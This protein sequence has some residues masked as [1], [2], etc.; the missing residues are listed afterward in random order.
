MKNRGNSARRLVQ[1]RRNLQLAEAS[2][3]NICGETVPDC[4]LRLHMQERHPEQDGTVQDIR[5]G[6]STISDATIREHGHVMKAI[7]IEGD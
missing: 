6:L 7:A 2:I 3:C 5:G 1:S 4:F